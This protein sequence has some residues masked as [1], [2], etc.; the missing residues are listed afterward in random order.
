MTH[1]RIAWP[2][3]LACYLTLGNYEQYLDRFWHAG[4]MTMVNHLT[5]KSTVLAWTDFVFRTSL[6]VR[7]FTKSGLRRV[8]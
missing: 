4:E 5:G 2:M 6:D 7:D 8:R 3:F 1:T